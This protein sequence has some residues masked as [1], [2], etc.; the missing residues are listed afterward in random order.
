MA[1]ATLEAIVRWQKPLGENGKLKV[2]FH[3]GEPLSA[4]IDYYR[5][6]LPILRKSLAPQKVQFDLQSN[7]WLLNDEFCELFCEYKVSIGT[8]LDGPE[9]I[10]DAQRGKGY[11]RRTMAGIEHAYSHGLD[12]GCICTFTAQSAPHVDEI[13]DFFKRK[14]LNF[15]IH[16]GLPSLQ[17][18][19][20]NKWILT[21]ENYGKL[22]INLLDRYLNN[23]DKLR[24]S[25]LDSLCRSVSSN[26]ASICTF[27]DCL[28][29]FLAVGP[30][31]GIYICQRFVGLHD[32]RVGSVYDEPSMEALASSPVWRAFEK[33]QEHIQEECGECLHLNICRGGCPYNSLAANRCSTGINELS[34]RSLRDPHCQ[35]YQLFFSQVIDRATAEVFSKENMEALVTHSHPDDG[36]LHRG[37]LLTIMRD[38][39]PPYETAA[40]ARQILAAVALAHTRDSVEATNRFVR[41]GLSNN[42]KRTL[43]AMASLQH[44]LLSSFKSLNNLYLHVTFDC[45]LRCSHCYA[46]G[47]EINKGCL[48]IPDVQRACFEA[49]RIG[50]RQ[51]VITGGEPLVYP[52]R[53]ALL[54]TLA[55][56]RKEIKPLLTV[57]RTSLALKMGAD[58]LQLVSQSTDE[59]V[60]SIDGDR[61]SHDARRGTGSYDLTVK[62]LQ[63]LVKLTG[64][65]K[66]SISAVLP[67]KQIN[68][69]PGAAVRA[70]SKELG[71]RRPHFRPILPIGRAAETV[72][73]MVPETLLAHVSPDDL[74]AFGYSPKATCG[75]GQN[76]YV[77]PDGAAFACYACRSNE[78]RLGKI[79]TAGGLSRVI[80]SE[81]FKNLKTHTVDRNIFCRNCILRYLCGGVC[82]AW[83]HPKIQQ[84]KDLDASPLNCSHMYKRARTLLFSALDRLGITIDKWKSADLPIPSDEIS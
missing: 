51:V 66:I 29:D 69:A 41:L 47:G 81:K 12:V 38:G 39:P 80:R 17:D 79:K 54:H 55:D 77:E 35:A 30:K 5:M 19:G 28:G 61:E 64:T 52:Q 67:L 59:T 56:L 57:L 6:A 10:N 45:P 74:I 78:W 8:S 20:G 72:L 9:A 83:A 53:N 1:K 13:F 50:F 18:K 22:L 46:L 11:Y 82:R 48:S 26:K 34:F 58:L 23:Q 14:G 49:A 60:I 40:R 62:N 84:I 4:G 16:A 21:S 27:R 75:I 42:K 76:L 31:G 25:T 71:I 37:K 43:K 63:D 32:Y 70:L 68:G 3:G 36:L 15:S 7:L 24:I 2:T 73:D 65:T 44:R 33:R